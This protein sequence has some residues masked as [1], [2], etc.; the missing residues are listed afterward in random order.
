MKIDVEIPDNLRHIL[1]FL[2]LKYI[3][4]P[5]VDNAKGVKNET[6]TIQG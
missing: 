2:W 1:N 4:M 3:P 6:I 5:D